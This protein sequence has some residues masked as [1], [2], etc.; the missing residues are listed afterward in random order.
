MTSDFNMILDMDFQFMNHSNQISVNDL[1]N[2]KA[3]KT[4]K[5]T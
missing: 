2:G 1:K 4:T 3:E 5:S